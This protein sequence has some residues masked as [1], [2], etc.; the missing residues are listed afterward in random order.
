MKKTIHV[1]KVEAKKSQADK[2]Y[3]RIET[4]LGWASC[5]LDSVKTK[6]EDGLGKVVDVEMTETKNGEYTN[7]V[8]QKFIKVRDG[9]VTEVTEEE[10]VETPV[11]PTRVN[12]NKEQAMYTS[13]VK[14]V[15]ICL[16]S[17]SIIKVDEKG[18]SSKEIEQITDEAIGLVKKARLAFR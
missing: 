7:R 1:K 2:T 17:S 5:F 18:L 14:D 6:L 11:K 15:F 12:N 16:Y 4:D 13:Y 3:W 8:I 10:V 9:D